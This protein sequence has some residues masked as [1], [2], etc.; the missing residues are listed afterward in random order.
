MSRAL[1]IVGENADN[2]PL[3][4]M[5]IARGKTC[6]EP[7]VLTGKPGQKPAFCA[8][9]DHNSAAK[10]RLGQKWKQED[11]AREAAQTLPLADRPISDSASRMVDVA[12]ELTRVVGEARAL[13]EDARELA[14]VATDQEA[15]QREILVVQRDADVRVAQAESAQADAER[16]AGIL[17]A[18]RDQAEALAQDACDAADEAIA[19][20]AE[21]EAQV[22]KV[23]EELRKVGSELQGM[24]KALDQ[25]VQDRDAAQQ[26]V[27]DLQEKHLDALTEAHARADQAARE[28]RQQHAQEFG[29][30][31]AERNEL[32]RK[33]DEAWKE[34]GELRNRGR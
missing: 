27:A 3:C 16:R 7:V 10:Y 2:T 31:R 23:R 24:R 15:M 9:P 11:R 20:R 26:Q 29:N 12:A 8:N 22:A 6:P 30:L 33:V 13:M 5:P 28:M 34:L 17:A 1:S 18:E 32:Q 4:T 19:A 14:T 25:A 21:A